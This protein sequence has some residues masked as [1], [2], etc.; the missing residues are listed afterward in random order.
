MTAE[1]D[2]SANGVGDLKVDNSNAFVVF[3]EF[4]TLTCPDEGGACTASVGTER[5]WDSQLSGNGHLIKK[6]EERPFAFIGW[7]AVY[8][9]DCATTKPSSG[10]ASTEGDGDGEAGDG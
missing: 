1:P 7:Y 8:G 4:A 9:R 10:E 2:V 3:E 6:K 5:I